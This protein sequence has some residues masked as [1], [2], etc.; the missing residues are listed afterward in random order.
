MNVFEIANIIQ[1]FGIQLDS[2]H[3]LDF[4]FLVHFVAVAL[5]IH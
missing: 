3:L 5:F 2:I 4:F 1:S